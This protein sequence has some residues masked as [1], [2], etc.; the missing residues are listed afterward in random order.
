[1]GPKSTEAARGLAARRRVAIQKRERR[2]LRSLIVRCP[3]V[4]L[5]KEE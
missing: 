1:M 4:A 3:H 5:T 2:F